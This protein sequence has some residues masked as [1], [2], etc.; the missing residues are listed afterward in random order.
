MLNK[1]IRIDEKTWLKITKIKLKDKM[2]SLA[3]VI[4]MILKEYEKNN[5]R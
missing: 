3:S 5:R 1:N 4:K 2:A